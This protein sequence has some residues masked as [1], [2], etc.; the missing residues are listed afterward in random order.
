MVGTYR[1]TEVVNM[2][3]KYREVM[4]GNF[5]VKN[6]GVPFIIAEIGSNHNGDMKLAKKLI[7]LAKESGANAVKFQEW[8][9]ESLFTEMI[10]KGNK[11]LERQLDEWSLNFDDLRIL[12]KH[13]DE[14][15]ILFGC[16]ATTEKG[17]DLLADELDVAYLKVASQDVNN[18]SLLKKMARTGKPVVLSTG[19]ATLGE[20]EKAVNVFEREENRNL[21]ILHC[22]SLYPPKEEEVNLLNIDMLMSLFDY[23]IGYSDHTLGIT[24]S[25][26]S[27]ARGAA[28]IEKHFTIDKEMKGWDHKVSADPEDMKKLVSEG[29]RI[30]KAIGR[31]AR[32]LSKRELEKRYVM[33]RSIVA[34]RDIPT[35]KVIERD[36]LELKRPGTGLPPNFLNL[37]IGSTAKK[38][39]RKDSLISLNELDI[40]K[41][42]PEAND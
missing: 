9:K 11:E 12:K 37:V 33:R 10:Y 40:K 17:V 41:E 42:F 34:N 39:I 20:I 4:I 28:L 24:I 27:I 23:P 19:M 38:N 29:Q 6:F 32:I 5:H 1:N 36:D 30:I 7:V 8:T 21:I 26:A 2:L 31:F 14:I 18:Y 25:L 22:V 3:K 15:G 13:S 35:G 16:T